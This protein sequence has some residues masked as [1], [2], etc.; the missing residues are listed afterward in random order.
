MNIF[1][2]TPL[3]I[4]VSLLLIT[5]VHADGVHFSDAFLHV[6]EPN[7]KAVISW[8]GETEEMIL[9]SAVRSED[10]ANFAWVIPIQSYTEPEVTEGNI[11]IFWDLANYF[12]KKQPLRDITEGFLSQTMGEFR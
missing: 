7:Q 6:H 11:S 12:E 9:S 8:D 10:I 2:K 3:L 5:I 4:L 1:K